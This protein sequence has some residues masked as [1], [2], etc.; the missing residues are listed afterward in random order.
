M[1]IRD[2]R[3]VIPPPMGE[4]RADSEIAGAEIPDTWE[5][6][7]AACLD[8]DPARRP[9]S[10]MEVAWRLGLVAEYE[11]R[12]TPE[13]AKPAVLRVP[14]ETQSS[15]ALKP[16]PGLNPAI[17]AAGAVGVLVLG[18]V[19]W[20]FARPRAAPIAIT[21]TP[22]P[23]VAVTPSPVPAPSAIV[24]AASP[25]PSPVAIAT[26]SPS[27]SSP[28]PVVEIDRQLVGSWQSGSARATRKH[29]DLQADGRYL[30]SVGGTVTDTGT[31]SA[32]N[33]QIEQYSRNNPLPFDVTYSFDDGDVVTQG[34]GPFDGTEW[35]KLTASSSTTSDSTTT[36][37]T[38]NTDSNDEDNS[39]A[40]Q[41]M[42]NGLKQR[43]GGG[44]GF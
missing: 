15:T 14:K 19:I 8:K 18:I 20:F 38:S 44:F 42:L 41:Q 7:V 32:V 30:V 21:S 28:A 37:H 23:A 3:D 29:W 33:G 1:C 4:R 24:Q 17:L 11:P 43:Y 13:T 2:R 16:A 26:P 34:N 36:H 9:Q 31:M 12:T 39:N 40:K 5:K 10:A 27:A 35:H 25:L 6:A 22:T